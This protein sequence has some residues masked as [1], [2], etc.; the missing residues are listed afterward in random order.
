MAAIATETLEIPA[1]DPWPAVAARARQW[2]AA[3]GAGLRDSVV[4]LP[5]AA[6]L[7]PVRAAF[8]AGG[9]WQPRIETPLT[10]A[11]ALAPPA[12]PGAGAPTGDAVFDRLQAAALLRRD[13]WGAARER[14]DRR[15]FAHLVAAFVDSAHAFRDAALAMAPADRPA[16]WAAARERVPASAGPAAFE[17]LL[18]R[19]ALEWAATAERGP[20]DALFGHRPAAWVI[21]RL[22]GADALSE[23][24]PAATGR[25]ALVLDLDA[26]PMPSPRPGRLVCDDAESEAQAAA[27]QVLA[28]LNAGRVPVG[29]VALDRVGVRRVR[30]LL[31][32]HA[33]P[34]LD[35]T[36]WTLSTTRAAA[37]VM[38]L[39]RAAAPSAG[40]DA[41]LDWLKTWPPAF[42][43]PH[44]LRQLES[45]WR[46]GTQPDEGAAADLW[47]R[48]QTHLHALAAAP[49][50]RP[51]AV[52][53]ADLQALL[54]A[55]G[56]FDHLRSDP[57][58]HQVLQSLRLLSPGAAWRLAAEAL[59]MDLAGFTAW[60]DAT[61]EGAQFVPPPPD[62]A[63]EVVLTPL[64]RAIGRPF[65]ELVVPGADER[66][67]GAVAAPPGLA[68]DAL[69]A[70]LGL[71]HSAERR[72]RQRQAF[73]ALLR[74]PALTLLRRR[75]DA[76]E[77][78][79]PSPE[80]E[81]A[82]LAAARAGV[83]WPAEQAWQL[84]TITLAA[85]PVVR[86]APTAP[87]DLPDQLSASAVDALRQCPYRFYARAVLRLT[88][89]DELEA[90]LAKRDYGTW[91]HGVLFR[92][93]RDR[94]PGQDDA[95]SL[96]AAADAETAQQ[97]LDEG[98]MLPFRAS[99]D[100]FA[101]AYLRWLQA[102][103]AAGWQWHAGEATRSMAPAATAP[104]R[105]EGR[106][107][108]VDR[109]PDGTLQVLD[110]KT[111]RAADLKQ[112]VN[113]PLEDTQLAFYAA[114]EPAATQAL[115]LALDERESPLEVPHPE[116]RA[117]AL[118]LVAQLGAELARLRQGAPLPALGESPACDHCEARGL[119]RRDHW[120]AS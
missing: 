102:R 60:V 26:S 11:A 101:P 28:A 3:A 107:D 90:G 17:M 47:A 106:L 74:A 78:L 83:A 9:G 41:R 24:L 71:A 15:G 98:E 5:F 93:H 4:L 69:A 32:R 37:R 94:Q 46:R 103:D 100:D 117:T 97:Q 44:A 66:H 86:P 85:Q 109:A 14:E 55:D 112:K 59:P 52:W 95:A 20:S 118:E 104:T 22:G 82:A 42:Q 70:A 54:Q 84:P 6:L 29:L 119:C 111:G 113:D 108:R 75:R 110:Y 115:Y 65:A 30:A 43:A 23:A 99:F 96:A 80:V 76:D 1:L 39:L 13:S 67:L 12:A 25:P 35:E 8:A 19:A 45:R 57:A 50:E 87:A 81:A 91:L 62:A 18:L 105:L 79:A 38:S 49:R 40:P 21:V 33:V 114:L 68:G 2:L 31:A 116:V 53:L 7:P 89:P 16:F 64:A 73:A 51:L 58:G 92:F 10:L 88:E 34:V 63:A 61:L 72:A 36:G 56:S 27:A 48:A 77:P 120:S